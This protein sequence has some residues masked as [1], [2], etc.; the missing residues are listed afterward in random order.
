MKDYYEIFD[1]PF[2]CS[3]QEI[4]Q[5]YRKLC[6]QYHPDKN[7]EGNHE[8]FLEIQEAYETLSNPDKRNIYTIQRFIPWFD[9]SFLDT[10][11]QN[12]VHHYSDSLLR[13][14]EFKFA[15]LLYRSLPPSC[16]QRIQSLWKQTQ[17]KQH[18]TNYHWLYEAPKYIYIDQLYESKLIHIYV[19]IQDAYQNKQKRIII[20]TKQ[21]TCFLF[22]RYF[23]T[24]IV[25]DNQTG[26][27][28]ICLH[29]QNGKQ[30][31]RKKDDLYYLL[32]KNNPPLFVCLPDQTIIS[33]S[34]KR[35]G[36]GFWDESY[37]KKGDL[38]FVKTT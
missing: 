17:E 29:T 26:F 37:Q 19:S 14:R 8:R 24:K 15:K 30:C 13:S 5:R 1:L 10:Q 32:P 6:L 36:F 21:G 25:I 35:N 33:V 34:K 23:Q 20:F 16:R 9:L 3:N 22:L 2:D 7:E 27:L 11:E 28:T 18:N 38:I 31:F 4:K 12:Y